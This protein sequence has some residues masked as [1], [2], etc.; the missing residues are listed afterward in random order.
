MFPHGEMLIAREP[1][2]N[3]RPAWTTI[4]RIAAPAYAKTL[5]HWSRRID[6]QLADGSSLV[7]DRRC[8]LGAYWRSGLRLATPDVNT[9]AGLAAS[10]HGASDVQ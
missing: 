9:I 7:T 4:E 3:S 5:E 8:A 1:R 10:S 6:A 2:G